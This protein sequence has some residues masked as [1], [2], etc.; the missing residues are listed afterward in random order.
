MEAA[1]EK[2]I[3]D[4]DVEVLGDGDKL[5]GRVPDAKCT[6][7]KELLVLKDD[8]LRLEGF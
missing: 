3:D 2:N 8:V 7:L 5:G 4:G 6:V 1:E